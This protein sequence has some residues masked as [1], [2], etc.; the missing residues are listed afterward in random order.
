MCDNPVAGRALPHLNIRPRLDVAAVERHMLEL[1]LAP[2]PALPAHTLP[3]SC[4]A[5]LAASTLDSAGVAPMPPSATAVSRAVAAPGTLPACPAASTKPPAAP[6]AD[7]IASTEPPTTPTPDRSTETPNALSER[8]MLGV[9][10]THLEGVCREM[11]VPGGRARR[12]ALLRALAALLPAACAPGV[13]ARRHLEE[14]G[15]GVLAQALG[16]VRALDYIAD[17]THA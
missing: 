7:P 10:R 17:I 8:D 6:P 14:L 15:A 12:L 2:R 11:G 9:C 13:L 1:L 16:Q 3:A 5:T 4:P